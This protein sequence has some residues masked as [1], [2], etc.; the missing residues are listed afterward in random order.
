MVIDP[1]EA[2]VAIKSDARAG[3]KSGDINQITWND[4]NPTNITKEQIETK[5]AELQA[6]EDAK[7]Y[8]RDRTS[9]EADGGTNVYPSIGDQLDMMWHDK[10]DDTSTW[11][12][13]VQA[14][15]NAH[16]KP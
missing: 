11:E 2:I 3:C 15:K 9:R 4:G 12:D 13:A 6:A 10:K 1:I 8:Q 7:Q 14:V 16:P 5:L